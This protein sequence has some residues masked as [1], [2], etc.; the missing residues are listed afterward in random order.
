MSSTRDR[1]EYLLATALDQGLLDRCHDNLT[2]QLEMVAEISVPSVSSFPNDIIYV[3]DRNKYVGEHFYE[4]RTNFPV[5]KRS[6][7]EF[8]SPSVEFSSLKLEIGNAD[9]K[10]NEILPGGANYRGMLNQ[11]IEVKLG[12]RDEENTYT[13]IFSGAVTD[14][15]GF[16]RDVSSFFIIARDKFDVMKSK[17]PNK[18]FNAVTYPDVSDAVQGQNLPVIYGD[19]TVELNPDIGASIPAFPVNS[20]H[21]DVI[22]HTRNIEMVIS[23]TINTFFDSSNVYINRGS[24]EDGIFKI[25]QADIVNISANNNTFEIVQN[26]ATILPNSL[27]PYEFEDG[28]RYL[29]RVKGKDIST[30]GPTYDDNVVEIAR[31]VLLLYGG[32]VSGDFDA[33]WNFYRDKFDGGAP[34][35]SIRDIKGR[36]WL[37]DQQEALTVALSL[38]EQVRAEAFINRNQKIQISALHFTEFATAT[39]KLTV[40]NW[41]IERESFKPRIDLRN[42]INRAKGFFNFLPD[43]DDNFYRTN[44]FKNQAAIDQVGKTLE[45]G[46]VFPNLYIRSDVN[47]QVKEVLRITSGFF[48]EVEVTQTW[49]SLLLEISDFVT[50]DVTIG[51]TV[52]NAIPCLIRQIGY[53][54]KGLKLPIKYWSFMSMPYSG[55]AGVGGGIVA[56]STATIEEE[57]T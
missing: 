21:P 16:G 30:A 23:E 36:L 15:G 6:I 1:K 25:D 11:T 50:M 57:T 22:L 5:I 24:G 55:W 33:S 18:T 43:L 7:G 12:L 3:S 53:S 14:I 27:D 39:S 4:A 31:D 38:L 41:D 49:R 44:F 47:N 13:T 20:L 34:Q 29:C 2:N 19:W 48:E 42:N 56:G 32:V 35:D 45:K 9:G 26:G 28:D 10:F 8:L 52:F 37:Q 51:S 40:R 54:S 46:L 17:F